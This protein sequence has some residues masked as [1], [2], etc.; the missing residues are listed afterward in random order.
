MINKCLGQVQKAHKEGS[1]CT[2]PP[3]YRPGRL[4]TCDTPSAIIAVLQEQIQALNQSRSSDERWSKW[5]DPTVKV[6]QAFSSILE[7][8]AGWSSVLQDMYLSAGIQDRSR[9]PRV[10]AVILAMCADQL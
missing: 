4:H 8:G 1:T 2:S 9:I 10:D 3:H 5:L 6:L 7:V